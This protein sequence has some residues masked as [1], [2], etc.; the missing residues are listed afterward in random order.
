MLQ[1]NYEHE[2][3]KMAK[4]LIICN[5]IFSFIINVLYFLVLATKSFVVIL[6]IFPYREKI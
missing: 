1:K 5:I 2:L 6:F 4:V 3:R